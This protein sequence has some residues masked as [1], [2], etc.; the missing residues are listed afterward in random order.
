MLKGL[1]SFTNISENPWF[2]TTYFNEI[3][4]LYVHQIKN[5]RHDKKLPFKHVNNHQQI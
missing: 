1:V 3:Y 2:L 5:S 4:L